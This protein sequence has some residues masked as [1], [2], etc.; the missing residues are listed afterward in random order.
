MTGDDGLS[1]RWSRGG[2]DG[3]YPEEVS[4]RVTRDYLTSMYYD[5]NVVKQIGHRLYA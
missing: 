3:H 2:C 1:G 4:P 5:V